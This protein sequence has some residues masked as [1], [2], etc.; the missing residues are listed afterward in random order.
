M[1]IVLA[2]SRISPAS[3]DM[4]I[5]LRMGTTLINQQTTSLLTLRTQGVV[6]QKY[7]YSCGAAALATLMTYHFNDPVNEES[8]LNLISQI[9]GGDDSYKSEGVSL[10]DLKSLAQQRGYQADG[11][12]LTIE[13]LSHLK[14][15]V[16]IYY[17]PKGYDH[18]SILKYV[19]NSRAYLSDPVKG[20][21]AI[22]V[23]QFKEEWDGAVL[24]LQKK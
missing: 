8:L 16:L 7:D 19:K 20:N 24:A 5:P 9:R 17:K 2:Y 21:V 10:L 18:F 14:S 4:S 22:P 11:Y 3:Q 6:I 15:P 13:Q 23:W 1:M 12:R